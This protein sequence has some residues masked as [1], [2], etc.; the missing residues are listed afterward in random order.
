MQLFALDIVDANKQAI[1]AAG[2]VKPLLRLAQASDVRVQRN[3]TGA[4]LNLTHLRKYTIDREKCTEL[5][6]DQHEC[7]LYPIVTM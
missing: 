7:K 1:V 2:G 5:T 4:L 6:A 3:A